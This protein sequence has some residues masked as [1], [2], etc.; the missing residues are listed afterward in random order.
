MQGVFY[1]LFMLTVLGPTPQA[2]CTSQLAPL[3]TG[4]SS[5]ASTLPY[6][7]KEQ[8]G[9]WG[10]GGWLGWTLDGEVL[11]PVTMMVRDLPKRRTD[12]DDN[13]TVKAVP[14]VAFA[15]RCLPVARSG[16]IR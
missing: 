9:D 4:T 16:P 13:V 12:D 3:H 14:D 7:R 10:G 5:S 8:A 2:G 6:W 11:V 15:V 1:T